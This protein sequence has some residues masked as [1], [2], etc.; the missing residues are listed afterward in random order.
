MTVEE[1]AAQ[2][3]GGWGLPA[4]GTFKLP[5]I[6]Y[7]NPL[8]DAMARKVAGNGLLDFSY[9]HHGLPGG[10]ISLFSAESIRQHRIFIQSLVAV[11]VSSPSLQPGLRDAQSFWKNFKLPNQTRFRHAESG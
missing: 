1:K 9:L 10:R 2:L 6:F 5:S 7:Q 11:L 4:I 3:E 8:N